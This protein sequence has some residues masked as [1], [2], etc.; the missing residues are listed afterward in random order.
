MKRRSVLLSVPIILIFIGLPIQSHAKGGLNLVRI[1]QWKGTA[2]PVELPKS[3]GGDIVPAGTPCYEV[4]MVNPLTGWRIGTGYDCITNPGSLV[5]TGEGTVTTYYIFVFRGRGSIISH[6][7]VVVRSS[8]DDDV[9]NPV[10]TGQDPVNLHFTH[11]LGSFPNENTIAGGTRR[12]KNAS[13]KVRVSGGVSLANFPD[14]IEFDD[15]FVIDF[16]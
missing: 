2:T 7:R 16:D 14:T 8:S 15:L 6:N 9:Y 11:I 10:P 5:V 13:G 4:E 3:V 1:V 12:F